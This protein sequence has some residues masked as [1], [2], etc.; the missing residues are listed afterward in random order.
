MERRAIRAVELG[1]LNMT[2]IRKSSIVDGTILLTLVAMACAQ[3]QSA[4]P[5]Q[6]PV[7]EATSPETVKANTRLVVVDVIATDS[8]GQPITGLK[9][10]DFRVFE[11]GREQKITDLI[12]REPAKSP[13]APAPLESNIFTNVPQLQHASS[14]NVVLL[15]EINGESSSHMYA[16]E[17]LQKYLESSPGLQLTAIFALENKKI[18][19]LH[20]FTT[21]AKALKQTVASYKPRGI[22]RMELQG[23]MASPFLTKGAF[24]TDE[25]SMENT[26][27]ALKSFAQIL[28]G[29]PGRKNLIWI[30]EAFP[31]SLFADGIGQGGLNTSASQLMHT[32]PNVGG[33][34]PLEQQETSQLQV[35]EFT[36]ED[37]NPAA[38]RSFASEITEVANALMNAHVSLYPVDA[39]GLG[40]TDLIAS[41][42]VMNTIA[43]GT[44]GRAF[45]NSNALDTGIRSSIDDGSTYYTLSY[46]PNN[47]LWN[48]RFRFIQIR[49]PH[50]DVNLRYRVGYYAL[51]PEVA[52]DPKQVTADLSEALTLDAPA[53]TAVLFKAGVAP[54]EKEHNKVLVN[55]AIDPHTLSFTQKEDG[56][57]H[58]QVSC[59][60]IVYSEKGSFIKQ[61]ANHLNASL[62]PENYQ[63]LMQQ[64]FPCQKT[65]DLKSGKYILKLGVVDRVTN[66]IGTTTAKVTV[67]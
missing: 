23:A 18:A 39:A 56:L 31:V 11:D 9:Q 21:D 25:T 4:Q 6:N 32:S 57:Q 42:S 14:L 17:R 34:I 66:L 63:K 8:K 41:Q 26:L 37:F 35:Q 47:K 2:I 50:P 29:Y 22:N 55:F 46:Y 27:I 7:P 30:S 45:Y 52:K 10:E 51:D 49:T 28:A 33:R 19:L 43:A 5:A 3:T 20:D 15:D 62:K 65:I 48:S 24:H 38:G 60:I 1:A 54:S 61:E 59:A 16:Q 53:T 12:F 58:A 44:G 13:S 67:P 40:K 64:Y 36:A